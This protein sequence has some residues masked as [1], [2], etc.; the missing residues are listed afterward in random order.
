MLW[1]AK[2]PLVPR[3]RVAA[4]E[5][6]VLAVEG[7]HTEI[8]HIRSGRVERLEAAAPAGVLRFLQR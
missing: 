1:K 7:R 2:R 4:D 5:W 8:N 3:L 6:I